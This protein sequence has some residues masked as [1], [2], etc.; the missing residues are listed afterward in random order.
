MI[1]SYEKALKYCLNLLA[2]QDYPELEIRKKLE[3]KG[4]KGETNR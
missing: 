1:Q 2:K 4:N 3:K